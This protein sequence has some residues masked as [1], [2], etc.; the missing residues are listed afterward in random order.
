M[1]VSQ[2]IELAINRAEGT[3]KPLRACLKKAWDV[4]GYLTTRVFIFFIILNLV[5]TVL[6]VFL[7]VGKL[8][9]HQ[10]VFNYSLNE[11]LALQ[12]VLKFFKLNWLLGTLA[13]KGID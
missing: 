11:V 9:E 12:K 8:G 2:L 3:C 7:E 10:L 1:I 6:K 13:F 4:R 5:E